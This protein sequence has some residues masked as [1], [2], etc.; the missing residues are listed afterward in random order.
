ANLIWEL[1]YPQESDAVDMTYFSDQAA[2]FL[3]YA[4]SFNLT[5]PNR[6]VVFAG[7]PEDLT[8]WPEPVIVAQTAAYTGN[9]DEVLE[10]HTAPLITSQADADNRADAILTRYNANRLAGYAV[11]HHDAQV[12][13]FDKPQ[14]L[15]VRD[16]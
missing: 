5:V 7:N 4:E 13:L 11:V 12:E 10:P 2:Y 8:P 3:K 9:Y 14:F 6:I 16:V 1:V 15:D